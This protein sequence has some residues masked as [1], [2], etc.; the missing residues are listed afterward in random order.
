MSENSLAYH[1]ADLLFQF[2]VSQNSPLAQRKNLVASIFANI[3]TRLRDEMAKDEELKKELEEL[4][5]RVNLL[6]ESYEV[7]LD[8]SPYYFKKRVLFE[9]YLYDVYKECLKW[10][11]EYD[12]VSPRI[13]E[14]VFASRWG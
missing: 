11:D 5:R 6:H 4:K 13:L 7:F 9:I 10:I 8:L 1:L 12:L 2:S 14:E 3:E